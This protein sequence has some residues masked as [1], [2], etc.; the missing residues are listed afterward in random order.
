MRKV[1][2]KT[3]YKL[4]GRDG[5]RV[6]VKT[7]T[8]FQEYVASGFYTPDNG[9]KAQVIEDAEFVE[10]KEEDVAEAGDVFSSLKGESEGEAKALEDMSVAELQE[11]HKDLYGKKKAGAVT[12]ET[13]IALIKDKEEEYAE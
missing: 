11:V 3:E 7:L 1:P 4:V 12:A 6:T 2:A 5:S 8:D 13:L 9:E 10:I